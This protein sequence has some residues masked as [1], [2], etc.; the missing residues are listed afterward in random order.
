[1]DTN[2]IFIL[3]IIMLV[4]SNGFIIYIFMNRSGNINRL[5]QIKN[6]LKNQN[7]SLTREIEKLQKEIKEVKEENNELK[8]KLKQIK[9]ELYDSQKTN[10]EIT[11]K[12]EVSEKKVI[13]LEDTIRKL[14]I[15]LE[16]L[17]STKNKTLEKSKGESDEN[18]IAKESQQKLISELNNKIKELEKKI[19]IYENEHKLEEY[20]NNL[21][22]Y[23]NRIKI[24][25]DQLSKIKAIAEEKN[26]E[27]MILRTKNENLDKAYMTIKGEL[28]V[29]LDKI[30]AL[31]GEQGKSFQDE[32][33]DKG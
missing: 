9:A 30:S 11:E 33:D 12:Y 16:D 17:K 1:M 18:K 19:S 23:Q 31:K 29:A 4:I 13:E 27:V 15:E 14:N 5:E 26:K 7:D 8:S 28:A 3:I 6:E 2:V 21:Q 10:K 22:L 24:L 32:Q 20:K 25:E